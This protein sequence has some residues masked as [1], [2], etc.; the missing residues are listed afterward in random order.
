MTESNLKRF[1]FIKDILRDDWENVLKS[2]LFDV[3]IEDMLDNKKLHLE[4]TESIKK[5][6]SHFFSESEQ[7]R[8]LNYK[9]KIGK[10]IYYNTFQEKQ[11]R[12]EKEVS[13]LKRTRDALRKEKDS[14]MID[15]SKLEAIEKID[16][17]IS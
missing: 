6:T 12:T 9:T 4:T 15:I 14:L 3:S 1:E 10:K 8:I 2:E 13:K 16:V 11:N 5:Q 17:G 7:A